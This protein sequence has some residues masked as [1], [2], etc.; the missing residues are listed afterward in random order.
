M[1]YIIEYLLLLYYYIPIPTKGLM[2]NVCVVTVTAR[3]GRQEL[4]SAGLSCIQ[5]L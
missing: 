1:S 5:M 2:D 3:R 4:N